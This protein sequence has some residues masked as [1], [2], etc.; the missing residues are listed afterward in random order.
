MEKPRAGVRPAAEVTANAS[1]T[2]RCV[3]EGSLEMILV[4]IGSHL[5]NLQAASADAVQVETSCSA[6][7]SAN[8]R[9]TSKIM[10]D[11]LSP[12]CGELPFSRSLT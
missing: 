2:S 8:G 3:R 6:K 10:V 12:T 9:F 5:S 11:G 1:T 7:T 4:A